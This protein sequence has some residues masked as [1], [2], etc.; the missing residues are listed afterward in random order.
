MPRLAPRENTER[1]AMTANHA[2]VLLRI[3]NEVQS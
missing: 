3:A 1:E 2:D